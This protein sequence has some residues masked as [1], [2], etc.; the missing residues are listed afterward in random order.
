MLTNVLTVI[1]IKWTIRA[2][3][4]LYVPHPVTQFGSTWY[5][6]ALWSSGCVVH[7][8]VCVA[9]SDVGWQ[10]V[11][12]RAL[13]PMPWYVTC[14]RGVETDGLGGRQINKTVCH[15]SYSGNSVQSQ[16][17]SSLHHKVHFRIYRK[18][19]DVITNVSTDSLPDLTD[20]L[21]PTIAFYW[22]IIETTST[23]LTRKNV[24]HCGIKHHHTICI[25][26]Y[27]AYTFSVKQN[28]DKRRVK[29]E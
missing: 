5:H 16:P 28:N 15:S 2:I 19:I 27:Q 14:L 10:C 29:M 1:T 25:G 24:Q 26:L 18:E 13:S 6:R 3:T 9:A 21:Y 4:H 11:I 7:M 8:I 23:L 17:R 12:S 20:V 22:S